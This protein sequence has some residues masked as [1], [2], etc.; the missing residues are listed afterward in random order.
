MSILTLTTDFG[1]K[2]HSVAAVKG[3]ILSELDNAHI[4]DISHLISPFHITEAAFV[5]KNAYHN[6]PKGSIH[7]IGV[8]SEITP[9]NRHLAISLDGHYFIAANNGILS[10]LALDVKPEEIVEINI[11]D[12]V[13]TN[14][15]VLDIFVKVAAHIARGGNLSVIGR[16]LENIKQITNITPIINQD[17]SKIIAHVIYID[18]FGNVVTN[19]RK[20]DF[21]N[22]AKGRKFEIKARSNVFKK[23]HDTY[24]GVV[25]FTVAKEGRNIEDGRQLALFNSSDFLELAIYK[26]NPL[27]VGGAASLFG[28][29]LRDTITINFEK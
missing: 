7:I 16:K 3:A 6:F 9:E 18:N 14:F 1:L 10:L 24:S 15:T 27:T 8:D 17:S 21:Q 12:R 19:V 23:I 13:E 2:D 28:L 26:S 25:D 11:H 4:V 5:I 20:K 22:I 29:K